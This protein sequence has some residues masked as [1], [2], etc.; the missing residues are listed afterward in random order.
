MAIKSELQNYSAYSRLRTIKVSADQRNTTYTFALEGEVHVGIPD[1]AWDKVVFIADKKWIWTHGVIYDCSRGMV[2]LTQ[3]EYDAI[4]RIDMSTI[5][6]IHENDEIVK[7]YFGSVP[8]ITE[9]SIA[10]LLDNVA[11]QI[12]SVRALVT[13][14][15]SD[16]RNAVNRVSYDLQQHAAEMEAY[17]QQNAKEL[18]D[19]NNS[20]AQNTE[21]IDAARQ[22][23]REQNTRIDDLSDH[24][25]A[26]REALLKLNERVTEAERKAGEAKELSQ[27][28]ARDSL[29]S[30]QDSVTAQ[31]AAVEAARAAAEA[32]AKAKAVAEAIGNL[33]TNPDTSMAGQVLQNAADIAALK[34]KTS[35]RN[36][37]VSLELDDDGDLILTTAEDSAVVGGEIDEDGNVLLNILLM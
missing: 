21:E 3:A 9:S 14:V 29:S 16:M 7:I 18:S 13:R 6:L 28:S 36:P 20:I 17:K 4:R 15:E 32:E 5:Y 23:I 12:A 2:T 30:R 37:N 22:A 10:A 27:Q 35:V 33:N 11:T 19:I 26:S 1:I 24:T 8:V 25:D 34:E 31:A